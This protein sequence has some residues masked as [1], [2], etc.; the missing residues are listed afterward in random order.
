MWMKYSTRIYGENKK[1]SFHSLQLMYDS[2]NN[3]VMDKATRS[4]TLFVSMESISQRHFRRLFSA[5]SILNIFRED[6]RV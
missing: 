5:L 4:H 6:T 1:L 3:C 2:Q